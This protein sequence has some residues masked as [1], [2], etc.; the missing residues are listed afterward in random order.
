MHQ[1]NSKNNR[2]LL[3]RGEDEQLFKEVFEQQK[4][5]KA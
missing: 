4:I 2:Q 3:F 1:I 5:Q